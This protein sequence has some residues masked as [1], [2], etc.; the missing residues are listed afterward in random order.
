MPSQPTNRRDFFGH[1][2]KGLVGAAVAGLLH[3][4]GVAPLHAADRKVY[5][6][7]PK[8]PHFPGKAKAVIQFHLTG[9]GGGDWYAVIE[10]GTCTVTEGVSSAPHGTITMSAS[11][12]VDLASG[13]L[14]G[15]RAFMT[16]RVK[17]SGDVT[18]LRKMQAWF[19]R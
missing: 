3:D 1:V 12:Y 10:S 17:T 6:V 5:D 14:G 9:K 18:L 4:D 8:Q 13:R 15:I 7:L 19:P 2:G 16:G 11:D